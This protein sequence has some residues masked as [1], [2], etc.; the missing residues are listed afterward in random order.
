MQYLGPL[1]KF[2]CDLLKNCSNIRTTAQGSQTSS[3][4]NLELEL[5]RNQLS[6]SPRGASLAATAARGPGTTL[7]AHTC[8]WGYYVKKCVFAFSK[9]PYL[10]YLGTCTLNQ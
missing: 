5:G 9:I 8:G 6:S 4:T 2:P 1:K 10:G 7:I 3:E